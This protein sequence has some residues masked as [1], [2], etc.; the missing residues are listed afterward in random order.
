MA[1]IDRVL[2]A[3]QARP[4]A[5]LDTKLEEI[6][7]VLAARAESGSLPDQKE[8]EAVE[9]RQAAR[10]RIEKRTQKASGSAVAVMPLIGTISR[11]MGM[12]DAMSGGASIETFSKQFDEAMADEAVGS[13]LIQIDS[14]GGSVYGVEELFQKILAARGKKRVV[15]VADQLAASAA[16]YIGSAAEEFV[17]TP[18]GEV[19]SIGV[20]MVHFDWSGN[21]E[22]SGVR[23]TII[24]AGDHKAEGNPYEPIEEET[25]EHLQSIVD[26]YY[27]QFERAVAKGRGVPV[28]KVR[29]DFGQGRTFTAKRA[30]DRG[31]VDRIQSFDEVLEDL[32]KGRRR[33]AA[34]GAAAEDEAMTVAAEVGE[35]ITVRA[36]GDGVEWESASGGAMDAVAAALNEIS[37]PEGPSAESLRETC[38]TALQVILEGFND[39]GTEVQERASD[40]VESAPVET[41]SKAKGEAMDEKSVADRP[42]TAEDAR[43][44]V[45]AER[46]RNRTIREIGATHKIDGVVV[47]N[48]IDQGLSLDAVNSAVLDILKEREAR[49][50]VIQVGQDREAARPFA[51]LGSQLQAIAASEQKGAVVD[52]RLLFLQEELEKKAA[53]SGSSVGVPSDAGYVVQ[54][55]F[56]EGIVTKMWD[57]GRIL[58][59]TNRVPIG[60]NSNALVRNHI[61]EASRAAGYRYGGVRVYRAAEAATV[62][63]SKPKLVEQRIQLEKLMGL[64]YATDETMQDAVALTVEAERGFRKELTFVAENEIFRGTGAGQCLGILNSAAVTSVAKTSAQAAAT[65]SATNVATMMGRLPAGSFS[66]AAWF[67]HS[68]VIP[69]LVLMTIGDQPVFLPGGSIAGSV[70]GTMFGMPVI[71]CEYCSTC[72]TVGDIILADLDQ[73]T[74]VD[75]NSVSWQESIHV[76]F[77]YDE[78]AFK[79]TYRFN[80]QPDWESKVLEFQ[81]SDYISPFITLAERA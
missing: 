71:P 14:P 64:Y 56:A 21:L 10:M 31:M 46:D 9:A 16:Y 62:T 81:G 57:E 41:A 70:F 38:E 1:N 61:K 74:T 51:T 7:Q 22:A 69:Q 28:G 42:E 32:Q 30:L 66:T 54:D 29:S 25:V 8:I 59:M 47:A 52:K 6:A 55:D 33:V 49:V 18:S 43:D 27:R 2:A 80:G 77:I 72:G 63:A 60:P 40:T 37:L 12:L 15:A 73:Y 17:V 39:E 26:D 3:V 68:S 20:Y 5:I 58:N 78:T 79:L 76:R 19:G 67:V 36:T 13:I 50:P 48:W 4:W 34:I 11:R 45:Q 53:A 35:T 75:K 24:K 44:L 65:V 23:P